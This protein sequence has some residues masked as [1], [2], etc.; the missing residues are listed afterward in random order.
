MTQHYTHQQLKWLQHLELQLVSERV[1]RSKLV[2]N[3]SKTKSIVF[4]T[5]YSLNPKPQ[6][7]LLM[8]NVEIEQIEITNGQPS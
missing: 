6:L 7:H 4:G 3:I 2:L 1:A 8:N 5:N